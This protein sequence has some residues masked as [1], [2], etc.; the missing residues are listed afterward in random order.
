MNTEFASPPKFQTDQEEIKDALQGSKVLLKEQSSNVSKRAT[1]I[2]Q[3]ANLI[4]TNFR[5]VIQR[6]KELSEWAKTL[7]DK[8]QE[9]EKAQKVFQDENNMNRL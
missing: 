9:L 6:E 7:L 8:K 5:N 3:I 2:Q 4:N 1:D